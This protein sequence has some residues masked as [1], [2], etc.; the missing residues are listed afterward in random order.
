MA[1]VM[2]R[3]HPRG[4]YIYRGG[5]LEELHVR[6]VRRVK[7]S[8]FEE[9]EV[10]DDCGALFLRGAIEHARVVADGQSYCVSQRYDRLRETIRRSDDDEERG[11]Q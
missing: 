9:S 3:T 11:Q 1:G 5:T 6:G 8:A 10:I 4:P 2:R 7:L